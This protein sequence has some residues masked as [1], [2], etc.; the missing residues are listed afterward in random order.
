MESGPRAKV[1]AHRLRPLNA[2]VPV[3]LRVDAG[4]PRAVLQRAGWRR[5]DRVEQVWRVDDGWWRPS[6]VARTYFR[7]GLESGHVITLYRD[8][9]EGTWWAQSY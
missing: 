4:V 2:P 3:Q 6:P 7:L 9:I 8:D 5:V 1:G